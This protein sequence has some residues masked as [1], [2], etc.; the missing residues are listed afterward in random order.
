MSSSSSNERCLVLSNAYSDAY[1]YSMA[2][3]SCSQYVL[4]AMNDFYNTCRTDT[5]YPFKSLSTYYTTPKGMVADCYI[6]NDISLTLPSPSPSPVKSTS[7]RSASTAPTAETS[8]TLEP[9]SSAEL[10]STGPSSTD[11]ST[12]TQSLAQ[13][14]SPTSTS[15]IGGRVM[16]K[17]TAAE[18]SPSAGSAVVADTKSSTPASV[19]VIV[20]FLM[21]ALVVGVGIFWYAFRKRRKEQPR[22]WENAFFSGGHSAQDHD[23]D[24]DALIP[25]YAS[26]TESPGMSPFVAGN[27]EIARV[28][29][30]SSFGSTELG[31]VPR[32]GDTVLERPVHTP[33]TVTLRTRNE[34]VYDDQAIDELSILP[35][36]IPPVY[37]MHSDAS[38]I[39]DAYSEPE[40]IQILSKEKEAKSLAAAP[41]RNPF[42]DI[43]SPSTA[44][45]SSPTTTAAKDSRRGM[46]GISP[47]DWDVEQVALWALTVDSFG[48]HVSLSLRSHGV[49][50]EMLFKLTNEQMREDLGLYR[51]NDRM[52]F[53]A[54]I[55]R[56][57]PTLA[58]PPSYQP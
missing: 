27:A 5:L 22:I 3:Q 6:W 24:N 14:S 38:H 8:P 20:G 41:Q 36:P 19:G 17:T 26:P 47:F 42:D 11:I 49:T 50:G 53:S 37:M 48:P 23:Q 1:I 32:R 43:L 56:L 13:I 10:P 57:R 51:L 58:A 28:T 52:S 31:P 39:I 15:E 29:T 44:T 25:L 16:T 46:S 30:K 40:E 9:S 2:P 45:V 55:E 34:S 35:P 7:S 33:E 4:N 18:I 12:S 21:G 54:A